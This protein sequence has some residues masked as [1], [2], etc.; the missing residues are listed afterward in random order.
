MVKRLLH[1]TI[2]TLIF[3]LLAPMLHAQPWVKNL[4]QD[5]LNNNREL[6]L[7]DFQKAFN[8]YWAPFHVKEGYYFENGIKKKA[9]GW[10]QFKRWEWYW[11]P[12]VNPK[13][14][15]F[16]KVSAADIRQQ[17]KMSGNPRST[18]G[19]WTSLG[20]SSTPGGYAGIGRLNCVAFSDN[21]SRF[22]VGAPAGGLWKT[23][24]GGTSWTPL[25][26][27]NAVL[28]VSDAVVIPTTGD[29]IIFIA[30]G[31][32]DGGSL[33]AL[34]GQQSHD[35]NSIG[36]LKSTDGG[37]TWSATGLSFS[38]S[39]KKTVNRL[40]LD[41]TDNNTLYAAT[42]S[43]V[44]K[45]T[46]AGTTWS[47][48]VSTA[49][50][51]M[52]FKPG[53]SAVLYGG[54]KSGTIYKSN[55]SGAT[56]SLKT[57]ISG[58]KRVALAVSANQPTWVYALVSDA[59]GGFLSIQK[60]TNS[61]GSFSEVF[62][63]SGGKNLL[64]WYCNGSDSGGQGGY[65][66]CIAADPNNA[67]KVFLGGVDTWYSSDGGTSWNN[68]NMW[69]S[70]SPYNTCGTPAVHADKHFL[71]YQN[72]ASTLFECND[73]GLYKTSN[74][75]TSWTLLSGSGMVISQVYR[76]GV[77]QTTNDDVIAG[78]QDNGTKSMLS[79]TW[80]D[81]IGGDGFDCAI[82]PTDETTQYG[83]LY[84]GRI[85]KTTNSWVGSVDITNDGTNPIHGIT[86][87]GLWCSPYQIDPNNQ[88]T[89]YVG[90]NNLWISTNQGTSWTK[91]SNFSG[92]KIM[93]FDIAPSN[94]SVIYVVE[95]SYYGNYTSKVQLT[96]NGGNSWS[97]V[98]GS[99]PVSSSNITDIKIKND[100]PN[101]AWVTMGAYNSYGVFET[102]D[103]GSTWTDIST[104]L[105][106]IPVMSIVQNTQ[107]TAQVELYVGTDV[108]IYVK[109]G[110]TNW[111]AFNTSLPNVVVTDLEIYYDATSTSSKLR[112]GTFGR[113]VWESD[114]YSDPSLPP[115]AD[116]T[117]DKTTPVV[118]ET[119]NFTDQSTYSPTNW[120][121]AF[122]P[123]TVTYLSGTSSTSQNPI[124]SFNATGTYDV[125]LYVEN[126]NGN[127]TK[128]KTGYITVGTG[129]PAYCTAGGGGDEYID[130][131]VIGT[132]SNTGTGYDASGYHDYTAL[133][134]DLNI[135]STNNITITNGHVYSSD[136][137]G[138]WVDWNQDGDFDDA[139]E[140]VV[141]TVD[142]GADGTYS[143]SVPASASLGNTRMRIRIKWNDSDCGSPCGTTTYGEVEDYTLNILSG[144]VT[145]QG[146]TSSNWDV[147]T[148]WSNAEVPTSSFNVT[149]PTT[150]TGGNFPVIGSTTTDAGCQDLTI[151]A[152]ASLTINGF[153]TVDGTLTN[154]A[155]TS[156]LVIGSTSSGTGS[157]IT[158]TDNVDGTVE[159]YLE[160]NEWHL[161]S[162]SANNQTIA[163]LYFNH[164]PDVWLKEYDES[165]GTDG[166]WTF[167][168][169][170]S[171]PMPL[172]KGF[173]V[174]IKNGYNV[175]PT[176]EGPLKSTD[177]TLSSLAYTD[178]SHG[179]NLIG[180][181][182]PSALDW[183]QGG[184]VK[185]NLDGSVWVYDHATGNYKTRNNHGIGSLTEGIIPVSS[186]FF[187]RATSGGASIT[188]PATAK[189]HNAQNFYK[190]T[191]EKNDTSDISYFVLGVSD[192]SGR[193]DEVWMAFSQECT[194]QYDQGWDVTRFDNFANAPSLYYVQDDREL[195][196][197]ALPLP[198]GED[199]SVKLDFSAGTSGQQILSL[200][201]ISGMDESDIYLEDLFTGNIQDM[202][203]QNDYA[204]DANVNESPDRFL[205]H[206]NPV[207]TGVENPEDGGC[208][209]YAWNK[210]IFIRQSGSV[211]GRTVRVIDL[212]GRK[213][214][215]NELSPST[216]NIIPV[217]AS[218]S[219]LIVQVID[220]K[221]VVTKKVF[222][223]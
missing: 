114:L 215:E 69:T 109:V 126:A 65:D 100:D 17:I 160:G 148:N 59:N 2:L 223:R 157:L 102:T 213:L 135:L 6:T 75:G 83:A 193:Q 52:E 89:L 164:N 86:E 106:S 117:A 66:L 47:L 133:S 211:K 73:G 111:T 124:V 156:G 24:D 25:T 146:T 85:K 92:H 94:S 11:T 43:G 87:T 188:I 61:G 182:F 204:F 179:Y 170:L 129:S 131:V 26:D 28:G 216:L 20:P 36:V 72:G 105:P 40:L 76:I 1:I 29:D 173:A 16:P 163:S 209:I 18:T 206:I 13:T 177:L 107:N 45:T 27:D 74:D 192:E 136:D 51:D 150:P 57:T 141:C 113:G 153:L 217:K 138:I 104:G 183:D 212:Y 41:P 134:T 189:V 178:A 140:N 185:T 84:Y 58:G 151:Q 210:K 54:T 56:W 118:G 121:W 22:Y 125:S 103:G 90:M 30:T 130:G 55:D 165:A 42:S 93:A 97:D 162:A 14:G 201:D 205:V 144:N 46:D 64:G 166:G 78:C 218:N 112:A 67:N 152:G 80:N 99:L 196:I 9:P 171:T 81:V 35:N 95:S 154:N 127:D 98:T 167:V 186:G 184:W 175:T 68:S 128:V 174:W 23:T 207:V 203:Q 197:D 143:F 159:R 79:G 108:G 37:T 116:F 219:T 31:D 21:N 77:A 60:S 120:F 158:G 169:Q 115:V 39:G 139:G 208:L 161:L 202:I 49:F 62:G 194:E 199:Q 191:S 145:W 198:D 220:G 137:L 132:I 122:D 88:Q 214:V 101:T 221:K 195:S 82:D 181:P 34:D 10:K 149:I 71:A 187:V 38:A 110:S 7:H 12:R 155:G 190:N 180:N 3:T 91:K 123:A 8:D 176:F 15:E 32:R 5:K 33:W 222:I 147:A 63:T 142:D 4:P 53:N 172:G 44:Y 96:T 168:W 70:G 200:K 48:L 19:S 50:I 119:V